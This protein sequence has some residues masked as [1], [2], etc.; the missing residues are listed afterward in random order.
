MA[1]VTGEEH[2]YLL[3]LAISELATALEAAGVELPAGAGLSYARALASL[4]QPRGDGLADPPAP[5]PRPEPLPTDA[6]APDGGHSRGVAP[7]LLDRLTG[8]T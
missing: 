4:P 1:G 8:R 5:R 2:D 7:R 6:H 3:A